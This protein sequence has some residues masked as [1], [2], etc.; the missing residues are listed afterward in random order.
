MYLCPNCRATHAGSSDSC[1]SCGWQP[2]L[3]E[4]IAVHLSNSDRQDGFF[5]E[6]VD[7]YDRLSVSDMEHGIVEKTYLSNQADKMLGYY[8]GNAKAIVEVGVGQGILLRKLRLR[9]PGAKITAVDISI[10]FL[11]HVK[12]NVDVECLLANAEN[13]PFDE[14][15]D[16]A[17]ASDILEHV[18]NPI[19]FLVSVNHALKPGGDFLLRV[20]FE[21]NML[22]YSRLLGC[23]YKFAHLRNFSRR[24]L[25]VMLNQAGFDVRQIHY[26][27]YYAY[28]RRAF[29]RSGKAK[30]YFD[31]F[32]ASR[33]PNQHDVSKIPNWLGRMLMKPL[34]IV[35]IAK[36]ARRVDNMNYLA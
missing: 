32:V 6:Y 5:N 2:E 20:P 22:Q 11:T 29:F 13:L 18:I 1:K 34:E 26:D 35:V 9:F 31:R 4:G 21:D 8:C 30:E 36:R 28:S 12:S 7:N 17:V 16:L 27:G 19:D 23:K 14:E 10:P 15:F 33:F 3:I 24:N 25:V